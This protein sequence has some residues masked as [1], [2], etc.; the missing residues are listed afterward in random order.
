MIICLSMQ[1][2]RKGP[3]QFTP[4]APLPFLPIGLLTTLICSEKH[5]RYPA[6]NQRNDY[7]R[8]SLILAKT[9]QECES[10]DYQTNVYVWYELVELINSGWLAPKGSPFPGSSDTFSLA[11]Q[12][13]GTYAYLCILHPWMTGQVVVK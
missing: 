5:S 12:K 9:F 13:A 1:F 6:L 2:Y 11:F 4:F 10:S 7:L 8:Y 3:R